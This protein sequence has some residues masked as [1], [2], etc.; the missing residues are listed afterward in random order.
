MLAAQ[1]KENVVNLA[2]GKRHF[3]V[4]LGESEGSVTRA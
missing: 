4:F 3:W 2:S 1:I